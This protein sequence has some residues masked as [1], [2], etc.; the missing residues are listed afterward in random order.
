MKAVA[1]VILSIFA[2]PVPAQDSSIF[3]FELG[4][5]LNLTECP[6]TKHGTIKYYMLDVPTT[7][8]EEA[9]SLKGYGQP[10]RR[11]RFSG[12][13]QPALV[14]HLA[15]PLELDGKMIGFHFVTNG[16]EAQDSVMRDLQNKYGKPGMLQYVAIQNRFGGQFNAIYA[17]W[18]VGDISVTF[19][20]V[21]DTLDYGE[22]YID[23]PTARKLRALWKREARPSERKM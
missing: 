19:N 15:Y 18:L 3:G 4:E 16:I 8:V 20:G 23:L 7:C 22:V 2:V 10:V 21:G 14:R 5:P 17:R 11:I 13:E 12:G 9:H 6:Y 1:A